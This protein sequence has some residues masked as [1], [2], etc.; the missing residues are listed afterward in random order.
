MLARF[1]GI[2]LST[3]QEPEPNVYV[4]S[5]AVSAKNLLGRSSYREQRV[6]SKLGQRA[7]AW[8]ADEVHAINAARIAGKSEAEIR[9][10]V[11]H[12]HAVRTLPQI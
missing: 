12:L 11:N 3:V 10:L 4:R 2:F 9:D 1:P 7:V 5:L 8:P 6:S